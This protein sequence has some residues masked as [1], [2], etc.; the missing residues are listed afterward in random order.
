V[1]A[2]ALNG[3]Q[4]QDPIIS[5]A[6]AANIEWAGAR[7]LQNSEHGLMD[8]A[9]PE[10]E[11]TAIRRVLDRYA[12]GGIHYHALR[13][14]RS[15]TRRFVSVHI[16]VPGEWTVHRGHEMVEE[17]EQEIRGA[18]PNVAVLTHLESLDDPAS[19]RDIH[20]DRM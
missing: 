6:N 8:N 15:G 7:I 2:V 18:L 13:T 17:I 16:L 4:R 12:A 19:W 10:T 14:R 11:Q 3:W 20:L 1:A 9:L 5:I